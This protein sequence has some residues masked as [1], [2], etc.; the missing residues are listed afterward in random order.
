MPG[1]ESWSRG[2]RQGAF[3]YLQLVPK[4]GFQWVED[5]RLPPTLPFPGHHQGGPWLARLDEQSIFD[6]H[7]AAH[8]PLL[9]PRYRGDPGLHRSLAGIEWG[10]EASLKREILSF[11]NGYGSLGGGVTVLLPPGGTFPL[12][13]V[14]GVPLAL[15]AGDRST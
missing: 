11:A 7:A 8:R 15:A 10:D 13:A 2:F 12:P 6:P 9:H 3:A 1:K 5:Y 14:P 4:R